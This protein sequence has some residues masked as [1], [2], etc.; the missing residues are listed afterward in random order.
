MAESLDRSHA[1]VVS[2]LELRD[3]GDDMLLQLHTSADA[4]LEVW[5][6]N[7]Y[8]QPFEQLVGKPVRIEVTTVPDQTDPPRTSPCPSADTVPTPAH[9]RPDTDA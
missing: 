7:R 1:Q 8:L 2:G 5:A 6:T 4:E 9:D 3:R